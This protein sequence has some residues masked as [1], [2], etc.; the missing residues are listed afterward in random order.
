VGRVKTPE[1]LLSAELTIRVGTKSVQQQFFTFDAVAELNGRACQLVENHDVFFGVA[2]RLRPHRRK[3]DVG[4][5]T[6]LWCD[7]DFKRFED[8]EAGALRRP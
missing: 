8:G 7:L 3:Q 5:T 6:G 1:E 2:P 4:V